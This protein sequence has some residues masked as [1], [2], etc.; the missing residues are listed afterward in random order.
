MGQFTTLFFMY[1]QRDV[2]GGG[3]IPYTRNRHIDMRV[4][5]IERKEWICSE[6][7]ITI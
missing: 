2:V 1:K 4:C 7:P 3:Q 5:S 6:R